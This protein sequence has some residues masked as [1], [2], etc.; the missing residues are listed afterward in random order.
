MP[1]GQVTNVMVR[2]D[3][4]GHCFQVGHRIRV[5]ISTSYW[6][7]ILPPPFVVTATLKTGDKSALHLPVLMQRKAVVMAEP[8][9][10]ELVPDYPM[11]SQPVS[12]RTVEKELATDITRFLIHEDTGLAV[13]PQNGMRFQE[14]RREAWQINRN[15][16][17][18]LTAQAH[19]TTVRSRD[20]WHVRTEI[21][22][23]LSV[24]ECFYFLEAELEAYEGGQ[25]VLH[26]TWE[27]AIKRDFT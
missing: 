9:S 18:T 26:R 16:P 13:H 4:A 3:E 23:T 6:P 14:I 10:T 27:K 21:K 11:I 1:A 15:D 22:Q 8:A 24:D 17:L 7:F 12:R 19:L 25:Q 5:A 2:L 20:S